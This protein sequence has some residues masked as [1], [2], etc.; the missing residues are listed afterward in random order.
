MHPRTNT[1]LWS[2]PPEGRHGDSG[3]IWAFR[4]D[5]EWTHITL[6][7]E[8]LLDTRIAAEQQRRYCAGTYR[9]HA[10]D[11]S[12]PKAVGSQPQAI[13]F[14]WCESIENPAGQLGGSILLLRIQVL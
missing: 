10:G 12:I 9:K 14:S 3:R 11:L 4:L 13:P 6:R 5:R 8:H 1:S 7:I 2:H